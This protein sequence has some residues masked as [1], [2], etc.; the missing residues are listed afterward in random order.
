MASRQLLN[1]H[2]FRVLKTESISA[3]WATTSWWSPTSRWRMGKCWFMFYK[4]N[5]NS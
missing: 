3:V 2:Y 5:N 1:A 4:D